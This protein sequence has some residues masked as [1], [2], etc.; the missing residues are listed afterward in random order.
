MYKLEEAFNDKHY[1]NYLKF[2]NSFFKKNKIDPTLLEKLNYSLVDNAYEIYYYPLYDK[3]YIY[4]KY[5]VSK[6]MPLTNYRL[7][8]S[9]YKYIFYMLSY[10]LP[11]AKREAFNELFGN[12]EKYENLEK[13]SDEKDNFL[14][15]V[16]Y[17]SSKTDNIY[18]F[19]EKYGL[20]SSKLINSLQNYI[21]QNYVDCFINIT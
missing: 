8:L 14:D 4:N 7:Y 2:K 15:D 17:I 5:S 21:L 18:V 9:F 3:Y 1:S 12:E 10:T 11:D 16:K 13:L 19:N 20:S 6:W